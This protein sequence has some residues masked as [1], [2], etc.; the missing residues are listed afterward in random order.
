MTDFTLLWI[1]I[2]FL[3]YILGKQVVGRVGLFYILP[4]L[5]ESVYK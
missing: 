5:Q 2:G 3:F 4:F 1:I